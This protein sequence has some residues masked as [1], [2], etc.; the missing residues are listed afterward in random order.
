MR[1]AGRVALVTGAGAGIGKAVALALAD[2]GAHVA[3]C[4]LNA[5]T[6]SATAEAARGRQ[7]RAALGR[8]AD[9]TD[10]ARMAEIVAQAERELGPVGIL[11][12]NAGISSVARAEELAPAAWRRVVEV[13]LTSL[14]LLAQAVGR[15]M[16]ARGEG[17]IVNVASV[18]GLRPGPLRVAYSTT[19]AGVIGLTQ[20]LAIEWAD[21]GVRVNAV[22]PGY[23]WTEMFRQAQARGGVDV[24][25]LIRRTPS[26][27]L[28]EPE[29]IASA[30]IFLASDDA[31]H[32]NGH[33]LVVDGAWLPNGGWA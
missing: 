32:I 4:D 1:L 29:E 16:L 6:V 31:R 12:N 33:T 19:K 11:V 30:I 28:A 18:Y 21:R 25:A 23:T 9:V 27:R 17:V 15:G 10:D 26:G 7:G 24:E 8:A 3:A 22:A 20:A 14:F 13:N 2:E 5:E